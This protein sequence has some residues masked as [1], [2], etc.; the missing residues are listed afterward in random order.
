M[1]RAPLVGIANALQVREIRKG[2]KDWEV[3]NPMVVFKAGLSAR[4]AQVSS[5][6]APVRS[7]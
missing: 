2:W 4:P 7:H 5:V 3:L 1:Q 6:L